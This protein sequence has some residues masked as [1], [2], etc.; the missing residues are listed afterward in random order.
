MA[1]GDVKVVKTRSGNSPEVVYLPLDASETFKLGEFVRLT[2]TDTVAACAV[3]GTT[4]VY[5]VAAEDATTTPTGS[6]SKPTGTLV[7]VWPLNAD[8][9]FS[10]PI[11]SGTFDAGQFSTF[12]DVVYNTTN[13]IAVD[14]HTADHVSLLGLDPLSST[15]VLFSGA[16]G[17]TT[18]LGSQAL[19]TPGGS[20][21][22]AV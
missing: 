2:T 13:G 3:A 22:R 8:T 19:G 15:R 16:Q 10:A 14:T 7:A 18:V 11:A 17:T 6:T 1:R 5:G 21:A 20:A 12:G 4:G 9:I